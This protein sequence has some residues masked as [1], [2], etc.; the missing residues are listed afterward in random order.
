MAIGA[1]CEGLT[2]EEIVIGEKNPDE[3][4]TSSG[5]FYSVKEYHILEIEYDILSKKSALIDN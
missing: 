4:P 1:A 2:R 5:F 3:S